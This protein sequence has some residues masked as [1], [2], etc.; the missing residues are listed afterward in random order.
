MLTNSDKT[1]QFFFFLIKISI[2]VAAFFFIYHKLSNNSIITTT[3]FIN[4]ITS[5]NILSII[6]LHHV[7]HSKKNHYSGLIWTGKTR[8]I[9]MTA[10]SQTAFTARNVS[11][12]LRYLWTSIQRYWVFFPLIH[13][14]DV[15]YCPYVV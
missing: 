5:K 15:F 8:C 4:I 6:Q 12:S 11:A 10:F 7:V 1:K 14:V 2:V 9:Y 3:D 13:D